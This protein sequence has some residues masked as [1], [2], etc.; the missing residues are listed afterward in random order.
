MRRS[1]SAPTSTSPSGRTSRS[2]S[3]TASGSSLPT[4]TPPSPCTSACT[5]STATTS[6]TSGRSTSGAGEAG[7]EGAEGAT[8][9][10]EGV[11]LGAGHLRERAAVTLV[12]HEQRVVAEAGGASRLACDRALDDS[13]GHELP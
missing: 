13:L 8:A 10:G 9:V 6:S 7:G 5:S 2:A 11:L 1:S 12:G 4:S 3:A